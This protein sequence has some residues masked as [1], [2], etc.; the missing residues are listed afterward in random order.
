MKAWGGRSW[1]LLERL[2]GSLMGAWW[3]QW[4]Q[5]IRAYSYAFPVGTDVGIACKA[6]ETASAA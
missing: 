4:P 5:K 6:L 3:T 1:M 2:D